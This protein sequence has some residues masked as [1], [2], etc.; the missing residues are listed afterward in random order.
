MDTPSQHPLRPGD[1]VTLM[2]EKAAFEGHAIARL[3]SL[4]VFVE[5]AVPGD[6]V[7]ARIYK[8]KKQFAHARTIEVVSPSPHRVQPS[9]THVGFC[10]G[11][12]WQAMS[13][14]QQLR[15]KR[16]HVVDAFERI[17][18]FKDITVRETVPSRDQFYYRN[19][20]EYSFGEK[21][22]RLPDEI[23]IDADAEPAFALG[24][25]VPGRFDKILHIDAC[26]LQSP[27]SNII[28]NLTRHHFLEAGLPA[29]STK[30]H[31]GDLRHLVIREAIRTG[32]RMVFLVST[33]ENQDVIKRYS[34]ALRSESFAGVT[35]FVHGVTN[36]KSMVAVADRSMTYFGDGTITEVLGDHRFTISPSSFFQTNTVQAERLYHIAAEYAELRDTDSVWD[37][38]C[39]AGT[40]SLFIAPH[41][42]HVTGVELNNYA[43]RDAIANAKTNRVTNTRF[44]CS[45]I[46]DFMTRAPEPDEPNPD[47]IVLDPPRAGVHPRVAESVG[48]RRCER[49]VYVSCNPT[50]SARDCAMLAAKGY[51][52]EEITPVD[53][54]PHTYHIECAIKLVL[55]R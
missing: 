48:D 16:E 6:T 39:G 19:K 1:I 21:R 40:I 24:L 15:W 25:H 43:I 52:I 22:W 11:C 3:E 35:T 53:M 41:V 33:H 50:T 13:Y 29:Y 26:W 7:R 2:P 45:D 38:Y 14:E 34:D 18:G 42:R 55:K 54:F 27:Q 28:L 44:I 23:D 49:I 9:C 17:G 36:R 30:S 4:V 12:T 47:V 8:K 10:G 46:V 37:L 32:E 20:M 51:I 31:T 5:G